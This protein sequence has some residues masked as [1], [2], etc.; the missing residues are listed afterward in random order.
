MLFRRPLIMKEVGE[1]GGGGSASETGAS[2]SDNSN[3]SPMESDGTK[4]EGSDLGPLLKNYGLSEE[5]IADIDQPAKESIAAKDESEKQL[6]PEEILA[7]LS[8]QEDTENEQA[9]ADQP[10][11]ESST[12][13]FVNSLGLKRNGSPVKVESKEQ[14]AEFLQKGSD[15]TFNTQQLAEERK[16]IETLLDKRIGEFEQERVDHAE[17]IQNSQKFDYALQK[18]KAGNPELYE[19]VMDF[20][21]TAENDT[22]NPYIKSLE[23]NNRKLEERLKALEGKVTQGSVQAENEKALGDWENNKA[24]FSPKI[25]KVVAQLEMKPDWKKIQEVWSSSDN[26]DIEKAFYAVHGADIQKRYQSKSAL[27]LIKN[28]SEA[29][30]QNKGAGLRG[31]GKGGSEKVDTSKMN[32]MEYMQ[33]LKKEYA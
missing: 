15:Y 5:D 28:K 14:L 24:T 32:D 19:A 7:K 30:K 29:L 20:A 8:G 10:E 12:L 3:N 9:G 31:G 4:S 11:M 22:N 21:T 25:E 16:N 2:A 33:H 18:M 27:N 23:S 13:D 17:F 1:D 26:F 6:S